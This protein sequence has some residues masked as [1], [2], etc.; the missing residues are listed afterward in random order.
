VLGDPL[1]DLDSLFLVL[2][3]TST[4]DEIKVARD[5]LAGLELSVESFTRLMFVRA[6]DL[7]QEDPGNEK[8]SEAEWRDVYSILVQVL[9][10]REFVAWRISEEAALVQMDLEEFW[11]SVSEP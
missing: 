3:K 11:V 9:K 10:K 1:P 4:A 7:A 8:V 2:T 5:T 6:K